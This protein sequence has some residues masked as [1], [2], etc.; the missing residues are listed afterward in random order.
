MDRV[1][2]RDEFR[3]GVTAFHSG[4]FS[5]S[6]LALERA[7]AYQPDDPLINEWLGHAYY[8]LG[9]EDTALS[10]WESVAESD[11]A[12]APLLYLMDTVRF[13]RGVSPDLGG[14]IRYVNSFQV[15][16]VQL[17][18]TLFSR[19]VSLFPTPD[20]G[21]YLTSLAGSRVLKFDANA[22]LERRILGGVVG[23]DRPFDVVEVGGE[24]LYVTES[25]GNRLFSSDLSGLGIRRFS[26]TGIAEGRLLGPQFL[27]YDGDGYLYITESGNRRVSKFDLDGNFILSFGRKSGDFAGLVNPTGVAVHGGLVYV[28]DQS[29][30]QGRSVG[31]RERPGSDHIAVF[32]ES[33]NYLTAIAEGMLEGPEGLS[34]Y[35]ESRLLLAD[36]TGLKLVDVEQETVRSLTD[37]SEPGVKLTK[38]VVDANG[39]VV[40]VDFTANT[41][42]VFTDIEA[43]YTGL[44]VEVERIDPQRFPEIAVEVR[45][46]T[47]E[48]APVVGLDERNFI[49]TERAGTVDGMTML[50]LGDTQQARLAVIVEDS[51]AVDPGSE[52]VARALRELARV[53]S[54]TG[55]LSLYAAGE[56]P[57]PVGDL[58][59]GV[60]SLI[61]RL[62]GTASR[63]AAW[64]FDAA[65]K[66][67]GAGL[68][69]F[70]GARAV[71][72]ITSGELGASPFDDYPPDVLASYLRN[73]GIAF[74]AVYLSAAPRNADVFDYLCEET[75]GESL[76][77]FRAEGVAR[78]AERVRS[79]GTGR[80]FFQYVSRSQ[81]D[82]GDAYIP[83]E[84][85][86]LHYR[87]SGR[88]GSAYFPP[89]EY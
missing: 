70:P 24:R 52:D 69:D 25:G 32:D 81:T 10:F 56:L 78:V 68:I 21:F 54:G 42:T 9:F 82:F 2:A 65:V 30:A 72:M 28:C 11:A 47:R 43:L 46:Q 4:L 83:V 64:S 38:A 44:L 75:G 86:V 88:G 77:V 19:P 53:V 18:F 13:R 39:N 48:G 8:R 76:F 41:L 16:G 5:E 22:A 45:V 31:S 26:E 74:Y 27:A 3:W 12:D 79:T 84:A 49:L 57:S 59:S 62:E 37:A 85:E 14:D 6:V 61:R 87:R 55:G 50:G 67:A 40:A 35:D 58:G 34:S 17:D 51:E 60:E 7:L 36:S 73:N 20:G 33:G 63:P 23:L 66:L 71:V 15:D 80:Y 89:I 1:R 29:G